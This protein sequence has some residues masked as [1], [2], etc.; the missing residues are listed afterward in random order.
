MK[1][2]CVLLPLL[3]ILS[4]CTATP[5]KPSAHKMDQIRTV[6]VV[7]V[8]SPP[9]EVIPDLI[10]TRFPV[11]NQFQYQSMPSSVYLEKTVYKNPGGVLIAGLVSKD[12]IMPIADIRQ[13]PASMKNIAGLE[14]TA[15]L[16]ENWIPTFILAQ[17]A[18]SQ[19]NGERIKAMLSKHYYHLPIATGDRN[20]NLGNWRNAVEQWYEQNVSSVDYRQ[21]GL[22]HVDAVL[23]VG[24]QTYSIF[25]AQTSLQVLVKL[26]DP[27][28]RQVIGRISAKTL[29][30]EDSPESLLNN[31]AERFKWLVA[32]MGAQLV[33]EGLSGLGLPLKLSG[34]PL[35]P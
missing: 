25:N 21:H 30:V 24:I 1:S 14:P 17:E 19:L 20:A 34:H 23:E 28:T 4:G 16:S 6:L 9:L 11:Y 8:E 31:E 27:D 3:F 10:E 35:T 33:T 18:A 2:Y 12:D 26:V 13:T 7:P 29:S 32:E 5:I 15:S 22:E